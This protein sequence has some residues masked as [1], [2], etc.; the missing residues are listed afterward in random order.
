MYV[1]TSSCW[2]IA[3]ILLG[4]EISSNSLLLLV[5]E[6]IEFVIIVAMI[7]SYVHVIVPISLYTVWVELL[8]GN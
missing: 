2:N 8:A 3:F 7:L 4:S 5:T 6:L 1:F